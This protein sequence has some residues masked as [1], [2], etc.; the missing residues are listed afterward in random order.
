MRNR[1]IHIIVIGSTKQRLHLALGEIILRTPSNNHLPG[2]MEKYLGSRGK[3]LMLFSMK[4]GIYGS[5]MAYLIGVGEAA[6]AIIGT[7]Q[8]I[9]TIIF[10]VIADDIFMNMNSFWMMTLISILIPL[11]MVFSRIHLVSIPALI[12]NRDFQPANWNITRTTPFTSF[13]L[14]ISMLKF[15]LLYSLL[16]IFVFL[17]LV[18][19]LT[20][21]NLTLLNV[22]VISY[23]RPTFL[24]LQLPT[25][26]KQFLHLLV[27]LVL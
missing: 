14:F 10:F 5:L 9:N 22:S 8:I 26:L 24:F 11:S 18:A 25:F 7:P 23:H 16:P 20:S 15:V 6:N 12:F 1:L 3:K 4:F 2:Y 27:F 21:N 17:N 19:I 13:S